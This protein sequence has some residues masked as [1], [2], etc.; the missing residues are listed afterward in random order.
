MNNDNYNNGTD[1]TEPL[2]SHYKLMRGLERLWRVETVNAGRGGQG[3]ATGAR[4]G[5]GRSVPGLSR[6]REGLRPARS[7]AGAVMA[8]SGCDG[9]GDDSAGEGTRNQFLR[10]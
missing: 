8:A 10:A 1:G 7:C 5:S 3:V 4:V 6:M 9:L 2:C